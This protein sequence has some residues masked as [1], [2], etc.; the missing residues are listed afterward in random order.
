MYCTVLPEPVSSLGDDANAAFH[1][2]WLRAQTLGT[3]SRSFDELARG[4]TTAYYAALTQAAPDAWSTLVSQAA[5]LVERTQSLDGI[6]QLNA[7]EREALDFFESIV[8]EN[9]DL[10]AAG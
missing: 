6:V 9:A 5:S 3:I 4:T 10:L 1:R 7:K 8:R 2:L